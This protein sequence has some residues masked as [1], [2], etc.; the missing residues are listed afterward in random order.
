MMPVGLCGLR[1]LVRMSRLFSVAL[2]RNNM[3]RLMFL[4]R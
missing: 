1:N 4:S 3:S 2:D